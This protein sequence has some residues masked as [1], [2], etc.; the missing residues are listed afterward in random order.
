MPP[1]ALP[2]KTIDRFIA[3]DGAEVELR[4]RGAGDFLI[5]HNGQVLMNSKAQRSEIALGQLAC[6]DLPPHP[7][8]RV[9]VGGLGMGFT[10]RAVLDALPAAAQVVVAEIN[11]R[12]V[13]WCRGSLAGLTAGA[14]GDPRVALAMGDVAELIRRQARPAAGFDAI[15]L[16]LYRGPRTPADQPDDPIYGRRAIARAYQ[17]LKPGGILAVWGEDDDA[18]FRARLSEAGFAVSCARPGK[19]GFRHAVF[20]ARKP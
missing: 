15:I 14:M 3:A 6:R 13:A 17:A 20:L 19:G 8:P 12:I 18:P 2:W 16:D 11:P 4:Q 10:L 5:F 7:P 1:M 9:L